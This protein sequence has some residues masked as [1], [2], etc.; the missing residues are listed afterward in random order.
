M[1]MPLPAFIK[2]A[3]N[4]IRSGFV[5]AALPSYTRDEASLHCAISLYDITSN[6]YFNFKFLIDDR[7]FCCT[8]KKDFQNRLQR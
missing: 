2:N 3:S 8:P 4:N 5:A 1:P 7:L 6:T